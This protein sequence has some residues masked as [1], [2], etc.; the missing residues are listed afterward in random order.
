MRNELPPCS[1]VMQGMSLRSASTEEGLPGRGVGEC[2]GNCGTCPP[3]SS[4]LTV[5]KVILLKEE[6]RHDQMM[7][8]IDAWAHAWAVTSQD[9]STRAGRTSEASR[10]GKV[11]RDR[12]CWTEQTPRNWRGSTKDQVVVDIQKISAY[13][14]RD[15]ATSTYKYPR[16]LNH[17]GIVVQFWPTPGSRKLSKLKK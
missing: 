3:P 11:C 12:A 5:K 6:E 17:C 16:C 9:L 13:T 1:P 7:A 8:L 2:P 10:D 14:A 4:T 15:Q